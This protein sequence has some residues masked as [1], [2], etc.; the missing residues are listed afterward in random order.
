MIVWWCFLSRFKFVREL[1]GGDQ[2]AKNTT[3]QPTR[4]NQRRRL[5]D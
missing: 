5:Q 3:D 2:V 1:L 4:R